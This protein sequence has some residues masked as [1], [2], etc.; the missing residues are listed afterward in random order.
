MDAMIEISDLTK[1]FTLHNQGGA[2][3]EV[4]RDAAFSVAPGECVGLVGVSG[5][6]KS[7]L[8]RM[9]YGNYLAASGRISVGGVD[10][11][12]AAPRD[13]LALRRQ[14]LGYVSQ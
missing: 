14:T 9:I 1:T 7:T 2:V 4:M 3:I 11:S 5:A 8:M 12:T 13:I 6:G 10:V